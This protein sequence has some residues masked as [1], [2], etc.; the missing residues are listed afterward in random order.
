MLQLIILS[1]NRL[2]SIPPLPVNLDT[3][4]CDGNQLVSIPNL[5][6]GLVSLD[7]GYN[8][9]WFSALPTIPL[10]LRDLSVSG[11][12]LSVYP[13]LPDSLERLL[14]ARNSIT[15]I[16]SLPSQLKI[17]DISINALTSLA[18]LPQGLERLIAS[19]SFNGTLPQ[20]PAS[21][22]TLVCSS[23]QLDTLPALP[24][25]LALMDCGNN[26]L[27]SLP[28]LPA[29][30]YGLICRNNNLT[31]LPPLPDSMEYLHCYNNP[32]LACMPFLG[33]I[34][35]LQ[36]F[37]TA[38]NCLPNYPRF[39]F[40]S[41]PDLSTLPLCTPFNTNGCA[42]YTTLNGLLFIDTIPNCAYNN[43][44]TKQ[45]NTKVNL[46]QDGV[47]KQQTITAL[48]GMYGFDAGYG[49]YEIRIDTANLPF[50]ITCAGGASRF[51]T[52]SA[53]DSLTGNLNFALRCK[54]GFDLMA[55][56]ISNSG[57]FRPAAVTGLNIKAGDAANFLGS[58]CVNSVSGTVTLI[59]DGPVHYIS[60]SSGSLTP[61]IVIGDT[62]KWN[63]ADFGTVNGT[64]AFNIIVATDTFA[65]AGS[66]VC[67]TLNVTPLADNDSSNNVTTTCYTVVSSF[68]PNDKQV[69]PP[70]DID[71][72]QKWL[73]YTVRFQ[74]TGT[75][76]AQHIYVM[77]TLDTNVDGSSF[78]LLAYSHQPQVLINENIVRF[79][80]A[81]INLPDSNTN[82]PESHGHIQYK[83]KL[84]NNLPVGTTISN[85][86]FIYF[87]FNAPV[88]T[89]TTTSTIAVKQDTT[90]VGI[91]SVT[92][93]A[94]FTL[95]PNPTQQQFTVTTAQPN[96]TL[97]IFDVEGRIVFTQNI[98]GTATT[99]NISNMYSGVY[100]VGFS[101]TN[102]RKRLI[103]L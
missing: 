74:N 45:A 53:T 2:V 101:N 14:M 38:I 63:V 58:S 54:S 90:T 103:K 78:Q 15:A 22:T 19:G 11:N 36:F 75:A 40:A 42:V 37:N 21:L 28:A 13:V 77:D 43:N 29:S 39:N 27:T 3:L 67:L 8:G 12:G 60:P 55:Q 50:T 91:P 20:L 81:N 92:N 35:D 102:V 5:P 84:K 46:L 9:S 86:A 98:I 73:T 18:P 62:V 33:A 30:C 57:R 61:T 72:L 34:D 4:R 56:S 26:N 69:S 95:Y 83:V 52:L 49:N 6:N 25:N 66:T 64:T 100:V 88:V 1:Y 68:D 85:T 44:E 94:Q 59:I 23:N 41:Q 79:N 89:N 24:P 51:D 7:C 96:Q 70:G 80:F 17:L 47:L 48:N 99:V 10:S 76:E 65:T 31:A 32:N 16:P 82:E 87:D 93:P 71:T 97:Q